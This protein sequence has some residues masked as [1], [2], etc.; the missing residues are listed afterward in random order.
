VAD[1]LLEVL[2]IFPHLKLMLRSSAPVTDD[3]PTLDEVKRAIRKMKNGR[4]PAAE[5]LK[6]AIDPVAEALLAIF[7]L[8]YVGSSY[9]STRAKD[10]AQSARAI[11]PSLYCRCQA[12]SCIQ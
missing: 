12:K 10:Q 7:Q 1:A 3:A 9:R 5:L 4:V 11:A 8:G 6:H 2:R